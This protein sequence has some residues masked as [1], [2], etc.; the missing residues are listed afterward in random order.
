MSSLPLTLDLANALAKNGIRDHEPSEPSSR[1]ADELVEPVTKSL[2]KLVE[3]Q[4]S[5]ARA[6]PCPPLPPLP[7]F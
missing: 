2:R 5:L 1:G 3:E 4:A 7:A 6:R